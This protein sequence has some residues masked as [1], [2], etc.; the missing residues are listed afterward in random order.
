MRLS[1]GLHCQRFGWLY[2]NRDRDPVYTIYVL[3][4]QI[5]IAICRNRMKRMESPFYLAIGYDPVYGA[6]NIRSD[7]FRTWD[8]ANKTLL[9]R[10]KVGHPKVYC[11]NGILWNDDRFLDAHP[12]YGWNLDNH[13]PELVENL[14]KIDYEKELTKEDINKMTEAYE[15]FLSYRC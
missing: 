12:G 7:G 6:A 8:E 13:V 10:F 14:S 1:G 3:D 2:M 4:N 9:K 11:D 5:C 15:K